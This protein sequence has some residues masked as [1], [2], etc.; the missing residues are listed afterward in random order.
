[1]EYSSFSGVQATAVTISLCTP[2]RHLS[3][4]FMEVA[5]RA[6]DPP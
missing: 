5:P 3:S 1:M 4:S 6:A 2:V